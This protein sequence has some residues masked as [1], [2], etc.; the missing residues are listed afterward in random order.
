MK[1]SFFD[2][3]FSEEWDFLET[4]N[5]FTEDELKLVTCINGSSLET[6]NDMCY[7]R[8][9]VREV[10]DLRKDFLCEDEGE[11]ENA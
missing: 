11:E 10:E 6:L 1:E 5:F 2:S 4:Y 3:W 7:A 8:Y 9:G